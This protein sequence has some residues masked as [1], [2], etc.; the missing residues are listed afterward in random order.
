MEKESLDRLEKSIVKPFE[1]PLE[2]N[3]LVQLKN[4]STYQDL[5]TSSNEK[6][7]MRI[8]GNLTLSVGPNV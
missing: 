8:P 3:S 2:K 4:H 5:F 7:S 6:L 1:N